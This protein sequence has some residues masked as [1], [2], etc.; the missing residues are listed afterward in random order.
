MPPIL[1]SVDLSP[2]LRRSWITLAAVAV[3]VAAAGPAR[4]AGAPPEPDAEAVLVGDG[5][6]GE[7]LYALNARERLPQASITKLMTAIVVLDWARPNEVVT[8]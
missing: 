4:A 3:L 1:V 2:L 8:V 7:V 5:L 6:T